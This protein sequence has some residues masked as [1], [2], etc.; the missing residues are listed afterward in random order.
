MNLLGITFDT[1]GSKGL[2]DWELDWS[3]KYTGEENYKMIQAREELEDDI[4]TGLN[5]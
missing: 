1:G 3:F 4:E 2:R 5:D